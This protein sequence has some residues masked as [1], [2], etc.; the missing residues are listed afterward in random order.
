MHAPKLLAAMIAS[1]LAS[2]AYAQAAA[3]A[4]TPAVL[5]TVTVTAQKREQLM[6]DVPLAVG[7]VS[8]DFIAKSGASS[9][10]DV[11]S[12]MPS[13]H[14]TQSQSG[15]QSTVSIRGVGSSGGVAGLDPSVGIYIDGIYIDRTWLGIGE[16]NDIERIEVL[17][18]P[19]GT[20]FGKNTPAGS[21]S[22]ITKK[23]S[24]KAAG[25]VEG[26][27]GNF[28]LHRL[29]FTYTAPLVDDKLAVRLSAFERK[30]NG[31]MRNTF[32]NEDV[33]DVDANGVRG[34]A[35]WKASEN[36]EVIF[37]LEHGVD[38]QNCCYPEFGPVTQAR[39]DSAAA[40]G[41]PFP[42]V[43][44][45]TDRQITVNAPFR[46]QVTTDAYAVEANYALGD[47]TVTALLSQRDAVQR[48]QIDADFTQIDTIGNVYGNRD[49]RQRSLE[50]RIASPENRTISYVAGLFYFE[51]Q[52]TELGGLVS[53]KDARFLFP[54]AAAFY[55]TPRESASRSD[56]DNKSYSLFGQATYALNKQIDL[57]GGLRYN[58]DQKSLQAGQV[59][60]NGP[61]PGLASAFGPVSESDKDGRVSGMV[62]LRYRPDSDT[63]VYGSLT[64]GYKSF[65]FN[66]GQV[67][68]ALNQK[69]FFN[70]EQST[71][72]EVG[73]RKEW[74]DNRVTTN[75][76]L[77]NT[78]FDNYQ[79]SSFAPAPGTNTGTAFLLQNAG[80]L[81]TRGVELE[82]SA[83]PT[84]AASVA[85]A[86]T[87][88]DAKFNDFKGGPGIPGVGSV[89]DLSGKELANAPRHSLSLSGQYRW[90]IPGTAFTAFAWGEVAHRS[91]YFTSQNL[92]PLFLQEGYSQVN[93]RVGLDAGAWQIELWAR[94]LTDKLFIYTGS[95]LSLSAGSRI[96]WINDPRTFGLTARLKF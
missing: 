1:A 26:T 36:L 66:D 61:M 70:A 33:N 62:N 16:F 88:L 71:S 55:T 41:K 69:R 67:N 31:T 53:G 77:F 57:T 75:V 79:A 78:V 12:A 64:R 2:G 84:R 85:L 17:R 30:R 28:G 14:F 4:S 48:G 82:L 76:T 95:R 40:I 49:L 68:A 3:P 80:K 8:S 65:G 11:V 38:R 93:A 37:T 96:T 56:I 22:Y 23:P 73:L 21:I 34:R 45:L 44:D 42:A 32:T 92:D 89:Q 29:A 18:G 27:V 10:K 50:L 72:T 51:K 15:G 6:Q 46:N 5:E 59:L 87:Y 35:L 54:G 81:T 25:E 7:V 43:V 91:S 47:H 19:Q 24:F 63:M 58:R 9:L 74:L 90:P 13:V 39:R 60:L 83:R 52:V 86:Y 94:N 20:L